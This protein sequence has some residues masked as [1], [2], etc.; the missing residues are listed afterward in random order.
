MNL[1]ECPNRKEHGCLPKHMRLLGEDEQAF[2]LHCFNCKLLWAIS[3][4]RTKQAAAFENRAR[5]I[6]QL[7]E[8][9]R[10][11]SRLPKTHYNAY[12]SGRGL[13]HGVD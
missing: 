9:E 7:T 12:D 4:L 13:I 6:K 8:E 5:T 10:R 2:R 11:I 3:K 1:P